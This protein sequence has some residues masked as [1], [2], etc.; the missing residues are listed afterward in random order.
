MKL[1][2]KGEDK[3]PTRYLLSPNETCSTGNG[4]WLKDPNGNPQTAQVIAKTLG[5][6]PQT[7]GKA[8]LL[9]ITSIQLIKHEEV[10]LMPA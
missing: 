5:D 7:D 9:K 2:N 4:S 3:T 6:S 10:D 1:P 8:L